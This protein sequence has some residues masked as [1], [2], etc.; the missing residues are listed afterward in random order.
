MSPKERQVRQAILDGTAP[1]PEIRAYLGPGVNPGDDILDALEAAIG[2]RPQKCPQEKSLACPAVS[3]WVTYFW[4]NA[5]IGGEYSVS[6]GRSLRHDFKK[7]RLGELVRSRQEA[8][9]QDVQRLLEYQLE[10]SPL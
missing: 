5:N 9:S 8:L 2:A 6:R 7:G 10:C 1:K 3:V 4:P